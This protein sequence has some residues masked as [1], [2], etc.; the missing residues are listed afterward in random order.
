MVVGQK[1]ME[2]YFM[3]L[4]RTRQTRQ[5]VNLCLRNFQMVVA[6]ERA[7]NAV[8]VRRSTNVWRHVKVRHFRLKMKIALSCFQWKRICNEFNLNILVLQEIF[9]RS[10]PSFAWIGRR[11]AKLQGPVKI[12]VKNDILL[13]MPKQWPESRQ[14]RMKT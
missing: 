11:M 6:D 7:H 13:F 1:K 12:N 4:A 3:T 14:N 2:H 5:T 8:P 9:S 10:V